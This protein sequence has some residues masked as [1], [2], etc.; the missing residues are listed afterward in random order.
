LAATNKS[1]TNASADLHD[2][3][4]HPLL[5]DTAG[6]SSAISGIP[7]H[8]TDALNLLSDLNKKMVTLQESMEKSAEVQVEQAEDL[9]KSLQAVSRAS[10]RNIISLTLHPGAPQSAVL[11]YLYGD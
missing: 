1:I 2:L 9:N 8:I 11:P 6:F 3:S 7:S 5:V 10:K 4:S